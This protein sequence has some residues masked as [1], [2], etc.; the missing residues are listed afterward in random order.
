MLFRKNNN[1]RQPPLSESATL[2]ETDKKNSF[3]RVISFFTL[4]AGAVAVFLDDT[5]F[6][7]NQ[8]CDPDRRIEAYLYTN[9]RT[10]RDCNGLP[11]W[12]RRSEGS[13]AYSF[14]F[15]FSGMVYCSWRRMR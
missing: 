10:L 4:P 13:G 12:L 14:D 11:M 7:G 2:R 3:R 5:V 1:V 8:G 6:Y 9:E 15:P